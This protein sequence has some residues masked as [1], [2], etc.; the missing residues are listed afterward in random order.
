MVCDHVVI[1]AN[2]R[3]TLC[4]PLDEL[5]KS[6]DPS[7]TVNLLGSTERFLKHL[8]R[9]QVRAERLS[10]QSVRAW[11]SEQ[12]VAPVLWQAAVEA[13]V[14]IRSVSPSRT[15]LEEVFL[16]AVRKV[17]DADS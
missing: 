7:V 13:D 10:D 1:L 2:G 16:T 3:M 14:A 6:S 9:S 11:G 8:R 15:S 12:S 5:Q 17:D 4:Q